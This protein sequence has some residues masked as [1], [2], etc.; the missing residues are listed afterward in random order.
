[1]SSNSESRT[2]REKIIDKL[3]MLKVISECEEKGIELDEEKLMQIIY[4][5]QTVSEAQGIETFHYKDWE[6]K[7]EK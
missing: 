7:E 2:E 3:L 5:I 6:W 1:M 4:I